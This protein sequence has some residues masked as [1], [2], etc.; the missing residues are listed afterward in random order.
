MLS[1]EDNVLLTRIDPGT[2]MGSLMRHYWIPA[3]P[4]D[5][6]PGPD[7]DPVRV[8]LMGESLV[9]FRDTEGRV[10]LL[11]ERCP[12]RTASLYFGRNEE[13]GIR[14]VYHGWKFDIHGDCLDIPSEPAGRGRADRIKAIAYPCIERGGLVWTYMGP[15]DKRPPFPDL[16]W[17]LVPDSHRF[18]TRRLQDCN[19]LQAL[20]GGFDPTH[21]S[22][23]HKGDLIPGVDFPLPVAS[24]FLPTGAGFICAY[25]REMFGKT[26]WCGETFLMPF[27]KL[28]PTELPGAHVW[29]PVDD[30]TTMLYSIDYNPDAPLT[31]AQREAHESGRLIHAANEAGSDRTIQ[32]RGNDYMID[33]A[34]QRSGRSYTGIPG[35]GVQDGAIQE[36][37]GRIADRTR[38]HLRPS[39]AGIVRLR[40][41]LLNAVAEFQEKGAV[42]ALDPTAYRQRPIY[43]FA[44]LSVGL[45]A[46]LPAH[47]AAVAGSAAWAV[48]ESL[49]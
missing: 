37:M 31:Q 11:D 30:E 27:H 44:P 26:V 13:S 24:E 35:V 34:V 20:E 22:F 15:P 12:H 8:R 17:T 1:A 41:Y 5:R 10:G 23:L 7:C 6:L 39:D 32:N 42:P 25:A 45:H 46:L 28:I 16:E 33:R 47:D 36:S 3:L 4:S 48:A 21:L 38:E 40:R 43:A 49:A 14:C 29:A 2:P 18:V 19:W 9:A